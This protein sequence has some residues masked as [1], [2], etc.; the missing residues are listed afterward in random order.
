M[1]SSDQVC[2]AKYEFTNDRYFSLK[3]SL[4]ARA[5]LSVWMGMFH[6]ISTNLAATLAGRAAPTWLLRRITGVMGR[7]TL[8]Q[9]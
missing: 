8:K 6:Y 4:S 1:L 9:E 5:P 3:A 2:M 7:Y